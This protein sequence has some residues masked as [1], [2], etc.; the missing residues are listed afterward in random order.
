M[1]AVIGLCALSIGDRKRAELMAA[2][3]RSAF[4]AQPRVSAYYKKSLQQLEARLGV[5]AI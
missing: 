1:R 3:A 5:K 2:Q 4:Q